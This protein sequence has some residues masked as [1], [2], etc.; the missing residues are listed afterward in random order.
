MNNGFEIY[1]L[2]YR[3]GEYVTSRTVAGSIPV[4]V[5]VFL[6]PNSVIP[7]AL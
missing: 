6:P 2:I 5:I 3:G 1:I 4:G 7:A